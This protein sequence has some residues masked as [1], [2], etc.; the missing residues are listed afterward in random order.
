MG[1]GPLTHVHRLAGMIYAWHRIEEID[2]IYFISIFFNLQPPH[3]PGLPE[4]V[5]IDEIQTGGLY[6][7]TREDQSNG[8]DPITC[9]IDGTDPT[10]DLFY[11]VGKLL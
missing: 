8:A 10:S 1:H 11:L 3:F 4:S 2:S 6:T 7:F 5:Y 9:Y